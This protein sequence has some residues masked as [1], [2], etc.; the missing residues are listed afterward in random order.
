MKR[1]WIRRAFLVLF[2]LA[3]AG[4]TSRCSLFT[5]IA[6][7]DAGD[8][9]FVRQT[10]PK[11]LG[12]KVRGTEET[13]LLVDVIRATPQG[14]GR[15]EV[16]TALMRTPEFSSHWQETLVD[17]LRVNRTQQKQQSSCYGAPRLPVADAGLANFLLTQRADLSGFAGSAPAAFNLSDVLASSMVADNV[18]PAYSAHLFAMQSKPLQ[19]AEVTEENQR[20]DLT[21]NFHHVY[22]KRNAECLRCHNSSFSRTGPQTY[23]NRTFPVWGK[24]EKAAFPNE[25][26]GDPERLAA[27]FRTGV[28]GGA[29]DN[30]SGAPARTPWG[31]L[32]GCGSFRSAAAGVDTHGPAPYLTQSLPVG[33]S[34]WNVQ[35]LLDQG[36]RDLAVNG[37]VRRKPAECGV[38]STPMCTAGVPAPLPQPATDDVKALL[39]SKGCMGCHSGST[40]AAGMNL[41]AANWTDNLI[42]QPSQTDSM[43]QRVRRGDAAAS[44]L[45]RKLR[46][47]PGS[48]S[49]MPPGGPFL[50]GTELTQVDNWINGLP[51][52]TI[53]I[54]CNACSADTCTATA[55]E[56][57]G[58]SALAFLLAMNITDQVWTETIGTPL[59]LAH[60]FPRTQ[61]QSN[62]LWALSEY[63]L[64]SGD[65]SLRDLIKR[66]LLSDYFNRKAP[67]RSSAPSAYDEPLVLDPWIEV[68]PRRPPVAQ[69]GWTSASM[70]APVPD[71]AYRKQDNPANH[72]NSMAEGIHRYSAR[73]LLYSMHAVLGWTA[74]VR[75]PF[76]VPPPGQP[77]PH[78]PTLALS[79]AIGQFV[80]DAE[81]GFRD[82]DFQGLLQWE[83][84]HK[85]CVRPAG[86]SQDWIDRLLDAV[87]AYNTANPGAQITLRDA[88][89][90]MKDWFLND[91]R[92]LTAALT[93]DGGQIEK[94]LLNTFFGVSDIDTASANVASAAARAALEAQLREYCGVLVQSPQFWLAGIAQDLGAGTPLKLRVC[95]GADCSYEQMC[96]AFANHFNIPGSRY[97][98]NCSAGSVTVTERPAPMPFPWRDWQKLC[99]NGVCGFWKRPL[100]FDECL[101]Q[102][103]PERC[104][105]KQPPRLDIGCERIDCG[106]GPLPPIDKQGGVGPHLMLG[107]LENGVVKEAS[108]VRWLRAS[109][110][111]VDVIG[112][113]D[114]S[115]AR[116][117]PLESGAKL[118]I[119]DVLEMP[120]GS[121]LNVAGERGS[122]QT[123]KGGM[124][125]VEGRRAWYM[126]VTGPSAAQVLP[127]APQL[128][129]VMS[130]QEEAFIEAQRNLERMRSVDPK[131]KLPPYDDAERQSMRASPKRLPDSNA[132]AKN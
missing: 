92:V 32:T 71:P 63:T 5:T 118:A 7:D 120:G 37:L 78:P 34:I 115:P 100:V 101:R 25:Q 126:M 82:T 110:R 129:W 27:L 113:K 11:L 65:W 124:P 85:T 64:V 106:G 123:P 130:V 18:F 94:N 2:V 38:C 89:L 24:F 70:A 111:G 46:G 131:R 125:N 23:W 61:S 103:E 47:T 67:A 117:K 51:A 112:G 8:A 57:E 77:P 29:K 49:Q 87:A 45:A 83:E 56:V 69:P 108:N 88:V 90:T 119:G 14:R 98:M 6:Q 96:Q 48:G 53:P 55:S 109:E 79:K 36:R 42:G 84:Q 21:V 43:V 59:T 66:I 13:K 15:D 1:L 74:P 104:L 73:S 31:S 35:S 72:N 19:G 95:N 60:H 76:D 116:F 26:G 20:A 68:D 39:N 50:S 102:G 54:A 58:P 122:F 114:V 127:A 86:V 105:P 4:C 107:W 81:P 132:G 93:H 62:V 9:S 16:L 40:P 52:N 22:L 3:I 99:T 128:R 97:V 75:F 10:V 33:S 28:A 12:R 80:R 17:M 91:P 121:A 30:P 41:Q 44:M